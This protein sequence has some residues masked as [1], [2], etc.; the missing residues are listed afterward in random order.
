MKTHARDTEAKLLRTFEDASAAGLFRYDASERPHKPYFNQISDHF[1]NSVR[2]DR[3]CQV[4]RLE[5]TS[6]R[7]SAADRD[8]GDLDARTAALEA[9]RG[10]PR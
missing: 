10:P 6:L 2:T 4:F 5:P 7:S 1:Q 9:D 8:T 3:F